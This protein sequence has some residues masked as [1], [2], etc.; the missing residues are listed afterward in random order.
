M[1]LKTMLLVILGFVLTG[2]E[3]LIAQKASRQVRKTERQLEKKEK[4]DAK[5]LVKK[6]ESQIQEHISRQSPEVQERMKQNR[7][8]SRNWGRHKKAP[9]YIK[10]YRKI[11]K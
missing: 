6:R 7:K 2:T 4:E 9:F 10:W 1:P 5:E 8:N 11:F 3:P